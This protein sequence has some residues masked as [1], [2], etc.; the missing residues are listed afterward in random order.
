MD[1]THPRPFHSL[2][3]NNLKKKKKVKGKK[4]KVTKDQKNLGEV[5]LGGQ[6]EPEVFRSEYSKWAKLF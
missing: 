2:N 3:Y 5:G 6:K 4:M 1:S